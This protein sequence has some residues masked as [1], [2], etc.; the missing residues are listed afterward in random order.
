MALLCSTAQAEQVISSPV[1]QANLIELYTSEGCS[2][3]PPADRW[4][5]GFKDHPELWVQLVPVAFHVDYWNYIGW[6]DR[7]SRPEYSER[8]RRYA[9]EGG[10]DV[11]YTP[12]VLSN[13]QEWRNFTWKA[14]A[15]GTGEKVGV[16]QAE[17]D[18]ERLAVRFEP[19]ET[20][21]KQDIV[22]NVALLGAGLATDVEAG[23]NRGRTLNHDFA[24][25]GLA[26]VR[27]VR[28]GRAYAAT[29]ALPQTEVEAERFALAVWVST[30][31]SQAPI[32]ATG[33]W[34][35]P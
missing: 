1:E 16:L 25:L 17:I 29:A 18:G 32:Q 5:S 21:R 4:L 34:L 22:A 11:V 35:E 23:E 7:F 14:P 10:V 31:D 15:T 28:D 9:R 12:G 6:K 13:G 3:C 26:E 33:G 27:L 8:Q 24:V 19:S 2:S 20:V 30:Q